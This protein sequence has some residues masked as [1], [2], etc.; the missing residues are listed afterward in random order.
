MNKLI[1][2]QLLFP[3]TSYLI[4]RNYAFKSDLKIKWVRPEKIL[5][6]KPA[7]SGDKSPIPEIDKSQYMLEFKNSKEL[8]T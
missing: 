3:K 2:P 1:N 7:K 8:E 5:S 6:I 4:S